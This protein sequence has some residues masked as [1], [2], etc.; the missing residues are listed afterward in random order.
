MTEQMR[1]IEI[2]KAGGPSVLKPAS[3]PV[4]EPKYGEVLD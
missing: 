4:P 2:T 3:R 1:V